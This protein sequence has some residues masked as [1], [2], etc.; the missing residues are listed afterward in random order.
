LGD[1]TIV[2]RSS[3]VRIGV[4][5]DWIAIAAGDMHVLA[6][7]SGGTLWAWGDNTTGQLGLGDT[8]NRSSPVQVGTHFWSQIIAGGSVSG[9]LRK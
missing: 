8:I 7:R 5:T 6:L 1:G 4:G 3:P 9:A 2:G